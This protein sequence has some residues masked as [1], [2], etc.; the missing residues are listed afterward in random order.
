MTRSIDNLRKPLQQQPVTHLLLLFLTVHHD[1][2]ESGDRIPEFEIGG[3]V[4]VKARRV[5]LFAM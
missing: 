1:S 2:A 5:S 3:G 4:F